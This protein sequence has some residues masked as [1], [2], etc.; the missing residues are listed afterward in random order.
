MKQVSQNPYQNQLIDPT[1][2]GANIL[3]LLSFENTTEKTVHT[4][5]YLPKKEIKDYGFTIHGKKL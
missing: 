1:I 4:G 5:Y 3:F 2:Q